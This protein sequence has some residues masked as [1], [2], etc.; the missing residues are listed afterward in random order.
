ML[1]LP[2]P[3]TVCVT[4][5]A[6]SQLHCCLLQYDSLFNFSYVDLDHVSDRIIMLVDFNLPDID[7][8]ILMDHSPVS[9]Q[10]CDLGFSANS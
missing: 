3:I 9:N 10:F 8:D 5:V 6:T 1:Q 4:Y 2:S 7:W